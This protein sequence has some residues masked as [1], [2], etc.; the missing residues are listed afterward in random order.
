[1][2]KAFFNRYQDEIV[3]WIWIIGIIVSIF[4][5]TNKEKYYLIPG[6]VAHGKYQGR[7]VTYFRYTHD[8]VEGYLGISNVSAEFCGSGCP[9]HFGGDSFSRKAFKGNWDKYEKQGYFTINCKWWLGLVT[10]ACFMFFIVLVSSLTGQKW[11]TCYSKYTGA[12][13]K[14]NNLYCNSQRC[15]YISSEN[16]YHYHCN[17]CSVKDYCKY[18]DCPNKVFQYIRIYKNKFLGY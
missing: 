3:F 15:E 1:M 8:G 10:M 14:F 16:G 2:V 12:G 5:F 4:F 6:S 9:G 13:Y 17:S 11:Q 7:P 18:S